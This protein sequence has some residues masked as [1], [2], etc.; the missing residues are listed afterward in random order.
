[1]C[2][3]VHLLIFLSAFKTK[4][5]STTQK[6]IKQQSTYDIVLGHVVEKL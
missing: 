3:P 5:N 4:K 2:S 6:L 1:M